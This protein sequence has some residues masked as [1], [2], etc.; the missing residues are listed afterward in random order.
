MLKYIPKDQ[1]KIHGL[2]KYLTGISGYDVTRYDLFNLY[3]KMP[4]Y[5]LKYI[6]IS[7]R[8]VYIIYVVS[9]NVICGYDCDNLTMNN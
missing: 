4:V 5:A 2:N 1:T 6:D 3:N 7:R 9:I 8:S